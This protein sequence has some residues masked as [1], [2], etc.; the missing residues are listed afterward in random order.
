MTRRFANVRPGRRF[1]APLRR[2]RR[3][4]TSATCSPS[5]PGRGERLTRRGRRP[6]PRLLEEPRHRRDAPAP[7]RSSPSEPGCASASTRCSAASTINV[8][9]NRAVLHVALR[10]PRGHVARRRRRAT[11]C[12]RCTRCSTAWPTFADRRPVGRVEGP[13]RQADPQRR[14]HRHRRLRPGPG[15]GLRGAAP[16]QRPRHDLPLR[17]ERRRHRL[18]RGDARPRPGGDAVHRLLED[19]HDARDDDQRAHARASGRC[20]GSA[21]TSARSRSTSSRCRPTPPRSRSSASTPP[22]C[23]ASGTGSAAATRWTRRSASRR[24]SRSAPSA[25]RE[26]LAG[27]HAMDEHFRDGA[28]RAEPARRSWGCSP[29][30]YRDFFG[31]QTLGVM[32]YEQYL[33]RFPAYLQ[34]LTMESNGKHVT[35][36]GRHVDYDTG[37]IVWGEP[38]TNGQHSFYQLIH[39]GTTLI[40]CDFIGFAPDAQPARRPP[41]PAARRTSSPRPRR[42]RSARPRTRCGPRA[43]PSRLVPH[44]TFE[45]NRPT[46]VI[47]AE[48]LTPRDARHARRALRAQRVHAGRRSGTST[49]STSGASSSGSSSR[50]ASS[51]SSRA[52][53]SRRSATTASTNDPHPALPP[54]QVIRLLL[55]MASAEPS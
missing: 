2:D 20:D 45:G 24:C 51:P 3:A 35:L 54:A 17:L 14:Q 52:R 47:L 7:R 8:T 10:M 55:A 4:R 44:R 50:S 43:R 42:S 12:R 41:R 22:T 11:W 53:R 16:L 49:R 21:A 29:V 13:H 1:R 48:R 33:K 30:W 25:S 31:A 40:P 28:V 39:Q 37:P 32:P 15:D 27:F 19:V 23:S 34:Q 46:N 5:D 36:D 6:L 38:G 18:R 26:M 9:E